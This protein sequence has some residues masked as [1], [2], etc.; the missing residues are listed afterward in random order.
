MAASNDRILHILVVARHPDL[1]PEF[2]SALASVKGVRPLVQYA[3]D[4]RDGAEQARIHQPRL[5]VVEIGAEAEEL[6]TFAEEVAV[7]SPES[8][9]VAIYHRDHFGEGQDESAFL[10]KALRAQVRDF[11]RWPVSS[12]ELQ[13]LLD[14]IFQKPQHE[15]RELGQVISFVSNK[16]GVGK[17]TTSVNVATA[18]ASRY[19]GKVLLVDASLQLG[20]A[21][22]MLDLE[23]T[24]T[25]ADAA[26]ELDRLDETMLQ[27]LTL[28]HESG[29]RLLAAPPDM[30]AATDVDDR[31]IT[32]M[33]ALARRCYDY[34]VVDTFPMLDA[35]VM[36]VLDLSDRIVVVTQVVVPVL[37]GTSSL[38][39]TLRRLGISDDRI[40]VVVNRNQPSFM[41]ELK[42]ADVEQRLDV[43]VQH[44]VPYEKRVPV[45]INTGEPLALHGGRFSGFRKAI[46][47]IADM[48]EAGVPARQLP[49]ASAETESEAGVVA[50]ATGAE[51]D[52]E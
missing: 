23:P 6:R 51:G 29:L 16:G 20:V 9:V 15:R 7:V 46:N 47:Q 52:L 26:R 8:E 42:I 36:S 25:I 14:R 33:L 10:I 49:A 34:V 40:Y 44:V 37:N 12:S 3:Y 1:K 2:D 39:A 50:G 11:L 30:L 17:S 32:R 28:S 13:Q 18:L 41:G 27:Q 24:R 43:R 48:L 45:S 19:P 4:P 22:S 5:V 38:L 31:A 35:I 21:A